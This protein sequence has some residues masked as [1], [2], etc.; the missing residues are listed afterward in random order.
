MG[1]LPKGAPSDEK[2]LQEAVSLAGDADT[3]VLALGNSRDQ[4]HEGIDRPDISFPDNQVA[5]AKAILALK[6]PTVLVMSNGG[7]L[8]LDGGTGLMDCGA[9]VEAFNPA[10][11]TPELA[12]LLFG[13]SNRWGKLPVTIYSLNYTRGGGGLP[14][15]PMD[16]YDMVKSPGRTYRWYQ[17]KP[18]FAYGTGLSLT[19]FELTCGCTTGSSDSTVLSCH[20]V[21]KNTGSKDGD[22]VI[23]VYDSL[24]PAIR[25]T[26]GQAHPLPIKRLVDF[27]RATIVAGES[28]TVHFE[29]EKER[30]AVTTA[31]GGLHLYSGVHELLFSRGNGDDQKVSVTV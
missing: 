7:T 31:D 20:C 12:E 18:L 1:P 26:V 19:T 3:V 15:Q 6:K 24:S 29:I 23:M 9:I 13:E 11:N 5:L 21:I 2:L 30:L 28:A 16:N 27:E 25:A 22:E 14:P 8:A 17:G 4:E 10:H